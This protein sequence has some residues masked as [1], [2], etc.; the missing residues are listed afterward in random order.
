MNSSGF[1]IV[2]SNCDCIGV[3]LDFPE[4]APS[5]TKISCA[6]CGSPRGTL[7]GLRSLALP[8]Q[9]SLLDVIPDPPPLDGKERRRSRPRRAS[10]KR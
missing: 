4:G 5:S 2:C 10:D 3:Q 7:G 1:Q 6:T 9:D 8:D